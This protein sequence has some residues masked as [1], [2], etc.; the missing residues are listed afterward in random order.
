MQVQKQR[1]I[2]K[3]NLLDKKISINFIFKKKKKKNQQQQQ[4][5]RVYCVRFNYR[6]DLLVKRDYIK[7]S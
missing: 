1:T 3:I 4:Q 6:D 5:Y 2:S 7:K